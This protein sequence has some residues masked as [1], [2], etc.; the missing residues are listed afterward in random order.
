MSEC[1]TSQLVPPTKQRLAA[2][3]ALHIPSYTMSPADIELDNLKDRPTTPVDEPA[4][5]DERMNHATT[6]AAEIWAYA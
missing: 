1:L 6:P 5:L 4:I 2:L 3:S